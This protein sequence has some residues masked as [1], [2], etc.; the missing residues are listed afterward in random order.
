MPVGPAI[1]VGVKIGKALGHAAMHGKFAHRAGVYGR[2]AAR[3]SPRLA[4]IARFGAKVGSSKWGRRIG[5]AAAWGT[6]DPGEV[7][8]NAILRR[9]KKL[10]FMQDTFG[11]AGTALYGAMQSHLVGISGRYGRRPKIKSGASSAL[12][13]R[14]K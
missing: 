13:R 7:V 1:R 4:K 10:R 14:R 5:T 6:F 2:V 9:S 3:S 11:A 12:R 8:N